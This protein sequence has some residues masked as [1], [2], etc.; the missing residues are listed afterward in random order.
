MLPGTGNPNFLTWKA[1]SG[2]ASGPEQGHRSIRYEGV[3]F[4]VAIER[5]GSSDQRRIALITDSVRV[6]PAIVTEMRQGH[7]AAMLWFGATDHEMTA[8]PVETGEGLITIEAG[9]PA[10]VLAAV[11]AR[12]GTFWIGIFSRLES[13]LIQEEVRTTNLKE[14]VRTLCDS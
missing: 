14:V 12:T 9:I 3:G 4:S 5:A 2:G 10:S 7:F 11:A 8:G 13:I 1:D 6:S